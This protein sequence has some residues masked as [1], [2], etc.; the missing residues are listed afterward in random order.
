MSVLQDKKEDSMPVVTKVSK[1]LVLSFFLAFLASAKYNHKIGKKYRITVIYKY[2]FK[3]FCYVKLS[4]KSISDLKFAKSCLSN[5]QKWS[6][7][8]KRE[9]FF[10][11]N[12]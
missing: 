9:Y 3:M 2:S 8:Q 6:R 4:E 12:I 7:R 10:A 11:K 5:G 1:W